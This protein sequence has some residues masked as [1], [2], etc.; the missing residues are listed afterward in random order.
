MLFLFL[1][2]TVEKLLYDIQYIQYSSGKV[3]SSESESMY[4]LRVAPASRSKKRDVP[5]GFVPPCRGLDWMIDAVLWRTFR[6]RENISRRARGA[7]RR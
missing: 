6:K 7:F 3:G 1:S 2:H 5:S 4:H